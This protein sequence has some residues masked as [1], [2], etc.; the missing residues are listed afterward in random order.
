MIKGLGKNGALVMLSHPGHGRVISWKRCKRVQDTTVEYYIYDGANVLASYDSDK[1]LTA[2]F[3]APGLDDNLSVTRGA[4]TYYYA[5]D[6]L[7]S[8][9]NVVDSSEATKNT[10]DFYAFGESLSTSETVTSP[11]RFTAREYE[12]GSV[13]DTYYYRNRYYM[14]GLGIFTSRDAMW[15]DLARGWGYVGNIPA[16]LIDPYGYYT[17][18]EWI[19][20]VGESADAARNTAR[21]L[22]E[23]AAEHPSDM[24]ARNLARRAALNAELVGDDITS[25]AVD[26]GVGGA[27]DGGK[28]WAQGAGWTVGL[29]LHFCYEQTDDLAFSKGMGVL[30]GLALQ[31]ALDVGLAGADKAIGFKFAYHTKPHPFPLIGPQPH[32]Q[33]V[34]WLKGVKGSHIIL[35]RIPWGP[36]PPFF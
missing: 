20:G 1:N 28:A 7:G 24:T 23:K 8:I 19:L 29:N 5:A 4:N 25:A 3:V 21:S 16:M 12:S 35:P 32:Y 17:P 9:R 13:L 18:W 14:S 31:A 26:A 36:M 30:G 33:T 11:F 6:G 34:V 27:F 22:A 15:A 2:R 10:Y